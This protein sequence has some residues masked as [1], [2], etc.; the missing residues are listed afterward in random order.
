MSAENIVRIYREIRD[1]KLELEK[2][3]I[4]DSFDETLTDK[5]REIVSSGAFLVRE[6][7]ELLARYEDDF[8]VE[9]DED[10]PRFPHTYCSQCGGEFGPGNHGYSHCES[11]RKGG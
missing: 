10:A 1:K 9:P 2:E 7:E 8:D 11:H 5:G 6:L 3:V 4:F